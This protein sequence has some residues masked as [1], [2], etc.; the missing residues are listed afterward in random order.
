MDGAT[1]AREQSG[2]R[3]QVGSGRKRAD[4]DAAPGGG[5]QHR[6]I[7]FLVRL[8]DAQAA[9]H[10]QVMRAIERAAWP[11]RAAGCRSRP[12][13]ALRRG[14]RDATDR[15]RDREAIERAQRLDRRARLIIESPGT[16]RK[17]KISARRA[18]A[19]NPA[20][21]QFRATR[22][23]RAKHSPREGGKAPADSDFSGASAT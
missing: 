5:A 1:V 18:C 22:A 8:L 23:G 11:G 15:R 14:S 6:E 10:E 7:A 19:R 12:R 4:A 17:V 13:S 3:Q 2:A 16:R 21:P 20:S 9:A